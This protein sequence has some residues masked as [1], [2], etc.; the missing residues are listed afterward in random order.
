MSGP[1]PASALAAHHLARNGIVSLLML[2]ALTACGP[3][4]EDMIDDLGG[5][6]DQRA[7]ARQELLLAKDR[8]VAPLL[9]ALEDPDRAKARPLLIDVLVSLMMRVDDD[10]ILDSLVRHLSS[11]PSPQVRARVAH[12]LAMHRRLEA[13]DALVS[14]LD[15][16][17]GEVRHQA[18]LALGG[19]DDKLTPAQR[20]TIGER[21]RSMVT[22][23]HPGVQTE[24][25]IR[26]ESAVA[27]VLQ[28]AAKLALAAQTTEAESLYSSALSRAPTSK[29][30]QYR[31]AR[32]YYDN[33]ERDKGLDLLRQHGMLLD[34]PRLRQ[35]PVVDGRMDA[36]E[37]WS[38]A[39]CSESFY[40]YSHQHAV[41]LPASRPTR[42]CVGYTDET[43]YVGVWSYDEHP[44][45]L[46]ANT[47]PGAEGVQVGRALSGSIW[48]DDVVEL[49]MDADF[50]HREYAHIGINSLGAVS[51]EWISGPMMEAASMENWADG[52]WRPRASLGAHVGDDHWSI[53]YAIQFEPKVLTRPEPG[54]IWGFNAVRTFRGQEYN[55]WTRTYSGGHSPNDFGLLLF[56]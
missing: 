23:P 16:G 28:E 38:G 31:L 17:E 22:D 45:S 19:M 56:H 24:A 51:P 5:D 41:A 32:F 10:R 6:A 15:D 48:V 29:R 14:A 9:E 50:D 30:A 42:L 34:V 39:A 4:I 1:L 20:E 18:L 35:L 37:A 25:R 13:F 54:S 52:E 21:A 33:G 7:A 53:E 49:F 43:L 47:Q 26:I 55:Q 3:S 40:I 8:S 11:D 44:D 2:L 46:V 27:D 36:D 12:A